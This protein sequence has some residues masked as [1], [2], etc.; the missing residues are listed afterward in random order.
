LQLPEIIRQP[1]AV[2]GKWTTGVDE[3]HGHHFAGKL[4]ELDLP[5]ILI[6]QGE[7]GNRLANRKRAGQG[8]T[9]RYHFF[10]KVHPAGLGGI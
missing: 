5:P 3:S 6:S 8:R 10:Q 4:R 9:G 2:V 7:I 1:E